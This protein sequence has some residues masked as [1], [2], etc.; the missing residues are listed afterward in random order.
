MQENAVQTILISTDKLLA[1]SEDSAEM[2]RQ[3]R[4]LGQA[5]AQLIQAIKVS[6]HLGR[7]P[8]ELYRICT[9]KSCEL[10]RFNRDLALKQVFCH[11]F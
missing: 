3:A 11:P 1:S 7:L 5:T 4:V 6:C 10:T 8:S 2:V 9:M